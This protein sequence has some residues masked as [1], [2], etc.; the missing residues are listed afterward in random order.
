MFEVIFDWLAPVSGW[1][2]PILRESPMGEYVRSSQ[3]AWPVLESLHFLGMSLLIGT[4]GVFDLRL[5]GFARGIPYAALHRLIPL[6]ISGFILNASTGL[7][8]ISGTPDQYLYNRAFIVKVTFMTIAGLNVAFFY[9]RGV[10]AAAAHG[11]PRVA[12]A[13][14]AAGRRRVACGLGRRDVGGAPADVLPAVTA[15]RIF[16]S[17]R[18]DDAAGDAG[19][20]AD[21]LHKRFGP[22][23]VFLDI[24]TIEPGTDFVQVLHRSL[25]E[26]AAV[27]VVIGRRWADITNAAGV[28]RLDDPA[29]FV[30]QEVEAALGRGVPVVPVLVQGAALPR[31]EELPAS[32]APLITRQ[33]ASLDH[34]EFH[35]DAERLCDRLAPL[36]QPPRRGWWPPSTRVAVAAVVVLLCGRGWRLQLVQR[37]GVGAQ[38]GGRRRGRPARADAPGRRASRNGRGRAGAAPVRRRGQDARGGA[39]AGPGGRRRQDAAGRRG[40]AV[41][42]RSAGRREHQDVRQRR[43]SPRWPSWIARCQAPRARGART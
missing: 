1:L 32:L 17:Y 31:A 40:H 3:W 11:R 35:A 14:R 10:Q 42:A 18:R 2:E 24:E 41:A 8:F 9:A 33:A 21:H 5:L 30:R 23:R 37:A 29:D 34:A 22:E 4:V 19:R 43:C 25:K 15:S 39:G 7:F 28:R 12:S 20:L 13:R 27:L 26:T 36:V 38:A 16:I 6:G